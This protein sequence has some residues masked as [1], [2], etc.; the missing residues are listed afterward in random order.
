M[1][2]ALPFL[3][4]IAA[5]LSVVIAIDLNER[6]RAKMIES[7]TV[8]TSDGLGIGEPDQLTE[9]GTEEPTEELTEENSSEL[10]TSNLPLEPTSENAPTQSTSQSGVGSLPEQVIATISS[11]NYEMTLVNRKY[12]MPDGVTVP[13]APA[14]AGSGIQLHTLAAGYYSNMY[15]AA[16]KDGCYLTPYS[17]YRSYARQKSNYE[18]KTQQYLNQGY[19]R[20]EALALAASVIMPPGSSEHNLGL[21]MDICGT[22][23]NF[24]KTDEFRW[25]VANAENYG[26]ILRY[27]SEKTY[28]TKVVYEPWHWRFVGVANAKAINASGLC[29]EEY[30]GMDA[31]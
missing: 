30:L 16:K 31:G 21:A 15:E 10:G 17:G 9:A 13:L 1:K 29:L 12:R 26:F 19:N 18:N 11:T 7:N 25:L 22:D 3:L 23:Y 27:K 6:G 4:L 2:K 28:I 5:F 14:A 20:N 8:S 24:D